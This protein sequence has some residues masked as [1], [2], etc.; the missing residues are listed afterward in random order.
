MKANRRLFLQSAGG[1]ALALAIGRCRGLLGRRAALVR[2]ARD[3]IA[4]L[5]LVVGTAPLR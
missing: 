2:I 1:A 3:R 4:A 5:G